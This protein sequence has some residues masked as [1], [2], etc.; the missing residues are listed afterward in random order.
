MMT[1]AASSRQSE[2]FLQLTIPLVSCKALELSVLVTPVGPG[3]FC[4]NR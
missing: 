1:A 2:K 3:Q 4:K